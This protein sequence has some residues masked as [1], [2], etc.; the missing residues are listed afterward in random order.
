MMSRRW[1]FLAV[2]YTAVYGVD[3]KLYGVNYNSRQGPDW[4]PNRCKSQAQVDIDMMA[5][6]TVASRVRIFSL[7]DCN[8]GF[9]VTTAAKKAGLGIWLGMW[10][11]N[12]QS[13]LNNELAAL[14]ALVT[15]NVVDNSIEGIHVGSESLYRKDITPDQAINYFAAVKTYLGTKQLTFPVSITDVLDTLLEYPQVI[16][17]VDVVMANAFPFW[18]QVDVDAAVNSFKTKF[19][20][21]VGAAHGKEV[22]IGETGWPSAGVNTNASTYV[23][24]FAAFAAAAE[25][26]YFM[27]TA[28]DDL[29]KIAQEGVI[30]TVEAHFGLFDATRNL[31][32]ELEYLTTGGYTPV[33]GDGNTAVRP[34]SSPTLFPI[35]DGSAT[36]TQVP[37]A[38]AQTS[39][40]VPTNVRQWWRLALGIALVLLLLPA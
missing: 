20:T 9:M 11:S 17:A 19:N 37:Q 10:V 36:T 8:Q 16:S 30:D 6:A 12:N 35:A 27:F 26:K 22:L 28:F 7:V 34:G 33:G 23:A 21:L 38:P 40:A 1:P 29:W 32:P 4:D 2:L 24:N 18:E 31:K 25:L 5:I 14:D 13:S 15:N 3:F 39:P